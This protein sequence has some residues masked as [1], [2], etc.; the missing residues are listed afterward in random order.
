MIVYETGTLLQS[1]RTIE[2]LSFNLFITV[3]FSRVSQMETKTDG[4]YNRICIHL[5]MNVYKIIYPLLE[6]RS[7]L[8]FVFCEE[9]VMPDL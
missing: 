8:P 3:P 9:E 6:C 7:W 2:C 1:E 4:K 5:Y